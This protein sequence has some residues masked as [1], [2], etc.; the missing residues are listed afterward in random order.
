MRENIS[1]WEYYSDLK[2]MWWKTILVGTGNSFLGN[3]STLYPPASEA[4][5]EVTNFYF[6]K[7]WS[8]GPELRA[9]KQHFDQIS[10]TF[11][12]E[13]IILTHPIRRGVWILPHKFHLYLIIRLNKNSLRAKSFFYLYKMKIIKTCIL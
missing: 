5:R 4:S 13:I 7:K 6:S 2:I 8:A 3:R 1:S 11:W 10:Q 12:Q 9:K